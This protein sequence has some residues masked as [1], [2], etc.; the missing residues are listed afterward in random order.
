MLADELGLEPGP[1]LRRLQEAILAHDPAIAAVPV[2]RRRRGNLPAPSTS[3]VGREDELARGRRAPARAPPRD[4]HRPAGRGQEPAR[5]RDGALA[6]GRV[7]GRH[8]ARRLRAGGRRGRRGPA[9]RERRRRSR[10]RP[11]RARDARRLRHAG[12]LARPRRVRA[13]PR[14]G[15]AHRVD[16]PRGVPRRPDPGDEPR[17]ASRRE[18]GAASPSRRS[19]SAAVDLFLERARAA[20]PG[21]RGGRGGRR[22]R[23][24]DRPARRRPAARDRARRRA[25]ERA[26]AR[27][28]S[29]RSSSGARRSCATARRPTRPAPRCK[30][31]SNGATTSCTA[32]RRRCSSSSPSTAAARP[33]PRSSRS[34][35]RAASTRRPS[36]YLVAALVDKSIVSASFAGGAARYDLLD[37]VREYVLDGLAE[38]GGLA[39]A[40]AAHAEYFA[41]L[42]DEARGGL[43]GP[44]WLRWE[45]RL[46]LENDNLWAALAYARDAP[47]PAVAVRLGTLGWYF[48]LADRVSEGR[49]FLELALVCH[50]TTTR[51]SSC[52]SS[53][54]PTSATSRPRSSISSAALAAGERAVS[55]AATAAAPWQSRLR[56]TD[57]RARPRAI[58]RRSNAPPRWRDDASAAFEAGGRRL[59]RRGEQ[60]HPRDRRGARR[61]RRRPS[62]RRPRWPAVTRTRSAT[63]RSAPR[64]SCSRRGRRSGAGTPRPRSMR[65]GA[66]SSSPG[67]S[68]SAT[69]RRS[70][71]PRSA[72]S[73]SRTATCAGPRSSS[74]RRSRQP[75]RPRRRGSRRRRASSSRAI[76]AAAGDRGRQPSSLYR[77][78][79]E[80]S[81]AATAAPGA[82]EPLRRARRR[83]G[84][85][86][87]ARARRDRRARRPALT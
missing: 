85:G 70:R 6:R 53:S 10:L 16:A 19:R 47:D 48:A 71:S 3:F 57:A 72:R 5:G 74:G 82:R 68:G 86:G 26:R 43:R 80:W 45:R 76:A 56:A 21:L 50:R 52:G 31:S 37:S 66:R 4:A 38:S 87:R 20:R 15:G 42:A 60:P 28:S 12:A 64:R 14:R 25:R 9:A 44:E 27:R 40:R 77:E 51:R 73:R 59:G 78:V 67:A 33:S 54:S 65:T 69:T 62:P 8:L 32:T 79:L 55:L 84:D 63:T 1:E 7:P 36:R 83:P 41:A 35:R 13:R 17:G 46:E 2:D 49:R 34:R 81:T 11:A 29:S 18:R 24:R 58:G 39:A 61:R 22:A 75:R 23:G 30:S